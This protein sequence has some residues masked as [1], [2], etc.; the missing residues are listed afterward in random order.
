MKI[1]RTYSPEVKQFILEHYKGIRTRE[2]A[3]ITNEAMGTDFDFNRMRAY[4]RNHCLRNGM[5]TAKL[6]N[7]I[8]HNQIFLPHMLDW[9]RENCTGISN[10]ELAELF[11]RKF[12]MNVTP[13]QIAGVKKN[14]SFSSG[15]TGRFE[16]GC[17]SPTKGKKISDFM[18]PEQQEIFKSYQFQ[19]GKEALNKLPVGSIRKNG[20]YLII[21]T[22]DQYETQKENW[23]LYHRWVWQQAHGPLKPGEIVIFRDNNPMNCDLDNLR[24]IDRRINLLMNRNKRKSIIPEITDSAIELSKLEVRIK[25]RREGKT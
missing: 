19:K 9:L 3:R 5:T 1:R 22:T 25:E 8:T 4:L 6:P 13:K 18:T 14:H 24:V 15:L 7:E 10:K 21:K 2:L 20:K 16:K 17:N 23:E 12:G 11:N